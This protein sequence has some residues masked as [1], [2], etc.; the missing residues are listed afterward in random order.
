MGAS[1]RNNVSV[2]G[3]A[4]TNPT[5]HSAYALQHNSRNLSLQELVEQKLRR[6]ANGWEIRKRKERYISKGKIKSR[7]KLHCKSR[8]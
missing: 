7:D 6:E 8:S 1:W 5:W 3:A 2:H 4:Y